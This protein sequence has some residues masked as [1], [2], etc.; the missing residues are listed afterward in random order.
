MDDAH[1]L[2]TDLLWEEIYVDDVISG[3]DSS[4]KKA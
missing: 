2:A 4:V 3:A 1:P